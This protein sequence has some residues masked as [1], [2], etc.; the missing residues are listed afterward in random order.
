MNVYIT[1]TIEIRITYLFYIINCY[2]YIMFLYINDLLFYIYFLKT[3]VI[4]YYKL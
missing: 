3:Y 1:N 2:E 4:Q